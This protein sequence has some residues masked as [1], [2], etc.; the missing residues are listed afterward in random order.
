[1]RMVLLALIYFSLIFATASAIDVVVP[2][3]A[4]GDMIVSDEELE[5]AEKSFDEGKIT[6]DELEEIR[7]IHDDYPI[8]IIDSADRAVTIY[9]PVKAVIPMSASNCEPIFVLGGVDQIAGM[10]MDLQ[11]S[12]SWIPGIEDKPTIGGYN[13]IDYEKVIELWPDIVISATSN[14]DNLE[15]NLG[16]S[17]I[18]YVILFRTLDQDA[19]DRDLKLLA[20]ILEKEERADEFLS[21]KQSCLD[22][23][24]EITDKI[25]SVDRRKVY[26]ESVHHAFYTVTKN[27][28][29]HDVINMAGGNNIARD[30]TGQPYC[31][32]VDPE[33][34]LTKNPDVVILMTGIANYTTEDNNIENLDQ[35]LKFAYNRTGLKET[36]AAE[37]G[38]IYLINPTYTDWGRGFIGASYM[39]RWFYPD[40]SKNLDPD[41][42]NKEYFE[43]WLGVPYQGIWAYPRVSA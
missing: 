27:S 5:Q 21:W 3:D 1:M 29:A 30:L 37:N 39:A 20:K 31:I 9:K 15:S 33:W 41:A 43:N 36:N 12:Y 19:Y 7:H 14:M 22:P 38:Q 26:C 6:S 11:E 8:T 24:K 13:E 25:D 2:G 23:L 35:L 16:P 42:I 10:R 18:P 32:D 17:E 4:D 34:V 40:I 28:G